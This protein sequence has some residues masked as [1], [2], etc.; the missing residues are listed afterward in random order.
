MLGYGYCRYSSDMQDE[1]SIEQQKMEINEYAQKN[2]IEVVAFYCDEAK[3]GTKDNRDSFQNMISDASKNKNIECVLVWKT[4]RFARNVQD[5]LYYRNKLKKNGTKLISITQPIDDS[6]PEGQLMATLLAGMD[7]Y[8]SQNLASNVKRAQKL[9]AQNCEF[10]GGIPPLGYKIV[11]KHYEIDEKEAIIVKKIFEKYLDGYSLIDIA[12]YLNNIGYK[13]K[14]GKSFGKNSIYDILGNIKY[15]GTYIY[16]KAYKHNSHILRNDAF[17]FNDA[18]PS[19]IAMEDFNM[20]QQKRKTKKSGEASSKNLY[21]LSG[22]ITCG[23]CGGIYTGSTSVK[24]KNGNVYKTGYYKCSNRNKLTKCDMPIIKQAEIED[25]VIKLLTDKLLNSADI[26]NVV[27][28]VQLEYEKMYN[29]SFDEIKHIET[30]IDNISKQIDNITDAIAN[31]ISSSSLSSKLASL[32]N[33]RELLEDKLLFNKSINHIK[34]DATYIKELLRKDVLKLSKD[35]PAKEI[36]KKWVKK[37]E[38]HDNE[39]IINFSFG[40]NSVPCMVARGRFELSTHWV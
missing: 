37:I 20:V 5:S 18:I 1:K 26:D 9:K 40:T 28:K 34:V 39:I 4:D 22:L 24:E 2:N 11:D 33:Q 6:T 36:I 17:I 30:E 14:K 35:V 12:Q 29:D 10:Q 25:I 15:T 23:K 16:N 3:S 19:I 38:V 32:E 21:L 7:E 8:Y 31:G 27:N 13:T